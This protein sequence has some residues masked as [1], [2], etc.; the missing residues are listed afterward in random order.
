MTKIFSQE[1]TL[2]IESGIFTA[3]TKTAFSDQLTAA[4]NKKI[5]IDGK[6]YFA[7]NANIL[8]LLILELPKADEASDR[9][10]R[11]KIFDRVDD[12]LEELG[13]YP[14]FIRRR[15]AVND[16]TNDAVQV[17][18]KFT[19]STIKHNDADSQTMQIFCTNLRRGNRITLEVHHNFR[20]ETVKQMIE[21]REGIQS[22]V[23]W[24]FFKRKQLK[25][26]LTLSDYNIPKESS[27]FF[28][29]CENLNFCTPLV[30]LARP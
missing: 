21:K 7:D 2:C 11:R 30:N 12:I 10:I 15:V 3:K 4:V 29:T 13:K 24:L 28:C 22:K 16:A 9:K 20:I 8:N 5:E 25:D 23:K 18:P 6:I 14:E 17:S 26:G 19:G 1:P 27:L